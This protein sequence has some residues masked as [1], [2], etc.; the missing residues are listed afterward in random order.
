VVLDTADAVDPDGAVEDV[1]AAISAD[2][3]VLAVGEPI[4]NPDGDTT[5][6]PV[7]PRTSPASEETESLV[8]H[9]RND[10]LRPFED[11]SGATAALTGQTAVL[12]DLSDKM[13]GA[14]PVFM[15]IVIGLTT[16]LLLVVFRSIVVPI[17]AALAILLSIGSSFGVLV[18]VFQ[19]GWL[20]DLVGLEESVPIISFLP[21]LM[22]AVLFGLSMDY[23]VFILSRIREEFV[24]TGEPKASVLTGLTSSA[25]V[26]SAA[27][28]IMISVFGSFVL[29]P[30]PVNKMLGIG[31]S[32]AVLLDAT[33]VRMLIVPAVMALFDRRAWWLPAWLDRWLPDLDVEGQ[34]L[35]EQ[36]D[37]RPEDL[38][39]ER[40]LVS[41]T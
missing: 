32:V 18:A 21:L 4:T 8:H 2:P 31:F 11:A 33:I 15:L 19:W 7:L 34:H 14:L 22:F 37:A 40:E 41:A 9:L 29:V 1:A 25:R 27:A 3:G 26:I 39:E 28:L 24:R 23:E 5:I 36:L 35:L 38:A 12:I 10:V 30:D 13:T 17:K 16:L 6:V 20:A